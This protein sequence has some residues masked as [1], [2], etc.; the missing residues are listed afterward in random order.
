[1]SMHFAPQWVKPIKPTGSSTTPISDT[2]PHSAKSISNNPMSGT[3]SSATS[4]HPFP[5]LS[6]STSH[7]SASPTTAVPPTLSYSRITHAPQSPS[8]PGDGS[9]F[10]FN[11]DVNAEE[12]KHPFRYSR[13]QILGVYDEDKVRDVPI[14][15]VEVLEGGGVLVQKGANRP[16]GLR[17]LTDDEKKVSPVLL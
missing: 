10:P 15:L 4:S 1:M 3:T 14:E 16:V 12:A 9:Y 17:E 6:S 2:P 8:V 5:A 13:E 7:R 11:G